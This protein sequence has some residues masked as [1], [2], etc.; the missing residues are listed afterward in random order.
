MDFDILKKRGR[1]VLGRHLQA[2][3]S[4]QL[5]HPTTPARSRS[6]L[7]HKPPRGRGRKR[8]ADRLAG[9]SGGDQ[10]AWLTPPPSCPPE[11]HRGVRMS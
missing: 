9:G 2:P 6:V 8:E 4:Q 3:R 7:C 5:L 1:G 10:A 11:A